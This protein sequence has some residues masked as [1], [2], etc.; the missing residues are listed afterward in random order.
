MRPPNA[1]PDRTPENL[2]WVRVPIECKK[3]IKGW[4]A[5]PVFGCE[6]HGTPAFK[7]CHS[8]FTGGARQCP[9]CAIPKFGTI[10]YQGYLPM[11]DERLKR[12]VV[13]VNLDVT[14]Q[15]DALPLLHPVEL[16]KGP[17]KTSPIILRSG[18]PWTTLRP[19]GAHVR[20]AP[21]DLV[22][23]LT[24]VLWRAEGLQ[25]YSG[26]QQ[27]QPPVVEPVV[28]AVEPVAEVQQESA[29]ETLHKKFKERGWKKSSLFF[30]PDTSGPK[31]PSK[32]GTHK[33]GDGGG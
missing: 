7:P 23:W 13:C 25:D 6:G 1:R 14:A 9:W 3:G 26:D 19:S 17:Y 27:P 18:E 29:R 4:L 28:E 32:N 15:A 10:K 30:G 12:T 5:G 11:Y 33:K 24:Q 2:K 20:S 21:Q 22:P 8:L 31:K 16:V